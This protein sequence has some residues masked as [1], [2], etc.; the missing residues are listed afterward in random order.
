MRK[1]KAKEVIS[2][3]SRVTQL[4]GDREGLNAGILAPDPTYFTAWWEQFPILHV[5][6]L[7]DGSPGYLTDASLRDMFFSIFLVC[8]F[9]APSCSP[10]VPNIRLERTASVLPCVCLCEFLSSCQ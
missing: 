2:N 3:L 9:L 5:L 4:G 7:P 10:P 1:L 6:F 8:F